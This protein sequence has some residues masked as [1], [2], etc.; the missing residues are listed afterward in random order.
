[1]VSTLPFQVE[2]EGC[3]VHAG[4]GQSVWTDSVDHCGQKS[5]LSRHVT[6]VALQKQH[7]SVV[8]EGIVSWQV[9]KI[10]GQGPG[11]PDG[12]RRVPEID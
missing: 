6:S 1:V 10:S 2:E 3:S 8:H 5:T 9:L 4:R 7:V 11:A 12:R